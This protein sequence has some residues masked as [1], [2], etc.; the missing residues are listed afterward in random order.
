MKDY[1]DAIRR[2][3]KKADVF[4][5]KKQKNEWAI[6]PYAWN[7]LIYLT[8]I[9][10]A[11]WCDIRQVGCVLYPQYPIAGFFV[12]YA[13]PVAKVAIE[14]DGKYWHLDAEKD[15]KRDK[16]LSDMGWTVYRI[17]GSDCM[18][19]QDDETGESGYAHRF[20]EG[21]SAIHGINC[22]EKRKTSYSFEDCIQHY[23]TNLLDHHS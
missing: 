21:I 15:E 18:T 23:L 4:I 7:G 9:E 6:D 11:L 5:L 19:E 22:N 13:N 12:D 8:P 1:W 20:V 2:H 14:C 16:K 17:T 3:Y 10:Q